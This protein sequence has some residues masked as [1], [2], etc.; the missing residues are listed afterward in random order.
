[1][2]KRGSDTLEVAARGLSDLRGN[3]DFLIFKFDSRRSRF[4]R[5][6]GPE[7]AFLG[8]S[9]ADWLAAD[10]LENVLTGDDRVAIPALLSARVRGAHIVRDCLFRNVRG[11]EVPAVLTAITSDSDPSQI[12][13]QIIVLNSE[14]STRSW[15]HRGPIAD[16]EL[17]KLMVGWLCQQTR[18]LSGYGGML[19]RHLSAQDDHVG[20][21]YALAMRDVVSVMEDMIARLR[22]LTGSQAGGEEIATAIDML[23]G[24]IKAA[25]AA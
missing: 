12:N 9:R 4:A 23:R 13:G 1:M 5:V 8:F 21:E 10:F 11:E 3:S 16:V 17:S 19:E 2:R 24:E 6:S 20:S 14:P 18:T 7:G 15:W 22:P 25:S